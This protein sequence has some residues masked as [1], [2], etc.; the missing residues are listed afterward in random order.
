MNF[1]TFKSEERYTAK[2]VVVWRSHL[3]VRTERPRNFW[4]PLD[5]KTCS[6]RCMQFIMISVPL[7]LYEYGALVLFPI[8]SLYLNNVFN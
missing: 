7:G 6:T 2:M 1:F 5:M 3:T 8:N 4:I